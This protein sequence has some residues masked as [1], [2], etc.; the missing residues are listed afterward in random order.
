MLILDDGGEFNE[1]R[2][3]WPAHF[4]W[5]ALIRQDVPETLVLS[6]TAGTTVNLPSTAPGQWWLAPDQS[7]H[8]PPGNAVARVG[9]V[10][11]QVRLV[12]PPDPLSPDELADHRAVSIQYLLATGQSALAHT[13]AAAWVAAAPNET[14]PR[15]LLGEALAAVGRPGAAL[16][17]LESG[18]Q[19]LVWR[20]RPP[21][22]LLQFA[23]DARERVYATFDRKPAEPLP[24]AEP[25]TLAEQDV[26]FG[27]DP[28]GQWA[29]NAQA[30][31]EYRTS[32]NFSA[33]RATGAPD[34]P[35]YGDNALAWASLAADAGPEWLEVTFA[36]PARA[37]AVRVR[38]TLN[39]GAI[40]RVEVRD[41]VGGT[42]T[43]YDGVDITPSPANQIAW[44][45]V[46][47]PR[48]PEPVQ[49][50]RLTLDSARAK[51]WNEI[52]AVQLVAA[53]AL[54]TSPPALNLSVEPATGQLHI[55]TW[56]NGFV[57]QQ[58]TRLEPAD[59]E[60]Y[61]AQPPVRIDATD[62]VA[63]FRL[64]EAP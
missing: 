20:D 46:K 60:I 33:A 4:H 26:A 12:N 31:S 9:N 24:P 14:M 39:P 28:H 56:P 13:Q 57:L 23:N 43:V 8:L 3:G 30:S 2:R 62:A 16:D 51:G 45:I 58:A 10:E 15:V 7:L 61:A 38:Q 44:F 35:R 47:F 41:T 63:F 32:G 49:R 52:D 29:T 18:F 53:P 64:V 11:L 27:A 34:V 22:D 50:V 54:P 59:W 42:S 6:N 40:V 17:S 37:N 36:N 55:A 19:H 1:V 48:T 21:E 5:Y 25:Q